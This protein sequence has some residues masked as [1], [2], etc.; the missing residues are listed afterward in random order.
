MLSGRLSGSHGSAEAGLP[1]LDPP[2]GLAMRRLVGLCFA[3][4]RL[5]ELQ[6]ADL[7]VLIQALAPD[8]CLHAG[9]LVGTEL[10]LQYFA[11]TH[12]LLQG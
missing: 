2:G 10:R 7:H 8:T 6:P 4:T 3:R 1:K 5:A 9:S 12:I 11:A